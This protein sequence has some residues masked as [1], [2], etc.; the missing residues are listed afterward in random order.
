MR[1]EL[2]ER[3]MEGRKRPS[4]VGAREAEPTER[5]LGRWSSGVVVGGDF[6]G[7]GEG[8]ECGCRFFESSGWGEG[9]VEGGAKSAG[10]LGVS[11]PYRAWMVFDFF[12]G[13]CPRLS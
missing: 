4:G 8:G 12:L 5:P 13:R 2:G 11:R 3:L 6:F 1:S 7:V 9:M 10:M